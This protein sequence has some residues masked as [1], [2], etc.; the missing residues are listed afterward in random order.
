M[1]KSQSMQDPRPFFYREE[2]GEEQ[3]G[4]SFNHS[5]TST[6]PLHYIYILIIYIELHTPTN[7]TQTYISTDSPHV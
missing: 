3:T 5:D 1:Q 6:L 2:R 4:V 7:S